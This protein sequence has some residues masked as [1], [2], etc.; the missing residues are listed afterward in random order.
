MSGPEKARK[1]DAFAFFLMAALLLVTDGLALLVT[2]PFAEV[3]IV[4][5]ENPDD[6]LG[7]VYFFSMLVVLTVMILL[8]SKF[9]K[10]QV[11]QG[12]VLGAVGLFL[13]SVVY[14]FLTG[15]VPELWS[16]GLSAA[17]TALV[18][19]LLVRY[20]EWYVIDACGVLMGLATIAV[21]GISLSI[22]LVIVL[23]IVM[24]IYDAVSVYGTKHMIDLVDT[25]LDLKLPVILV[26]P[27]SRKYSLLKETKSL[28]R[29]L[30]EQE[31]REASF[32]GLGDVV[33]PGTLVVSTFHNLSSNG[34]LIAVSVMLGTIFGF[35]VLAMSLMKGKPQA[36]LPY[37][38]GGAILGY[39]VSS[40]L[41]FG[42]LVGLSL[43]GGPH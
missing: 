3:G 9:W 2:K 31:E 25:V 32:M 30:E 29:K 43:L 35:A 8:I 27:K 20:P 16:L 38:C 33:F 13:F 34:L 28:K 5:F 36:G 42:Q 14:A 4:A 39:V 15:V 22:S 40:Y 1:R 10:R 11:V 41:V 24:A 12:I 37:L 6:P 19:V 17:V 23:L 26:I 7:L 21:F 18:L